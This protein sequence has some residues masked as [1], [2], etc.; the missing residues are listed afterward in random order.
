LRVLLGTLAFVQEHDRA[1]FDI[2]DNS[3]RHFRRI[4]PDCVESTH[5]PTD[6]LQVAS[7]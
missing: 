7:I 1:R 4:A 5:G 6:Q 3:F 2:L